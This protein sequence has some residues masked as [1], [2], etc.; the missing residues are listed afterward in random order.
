MVPQVMFLFKL[1][2]LYS[3]WLCFLNH[4]GNHSQLSET[5]GFSLRCSV[6][7]PFWFHLQKSSPI[8]T[9]CL[10]PVL[11]LPG[12]L[13]PQ[14]HFL[15]FVFWS[16]L[17][18]CKV[19]AGCLLGVCRESAGFRTPPSGFWGAWG[20][21]AGRFLQVGFCYFPRPPPGRQ[22]AAHRRHRP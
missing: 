17:G 15:P 5:Q 3:F 21:F 13:I 19:S 11:S 4:L 7:V 18:V 22:L 20:G 12:T 9:L 2:A 1:H 10:P 14:F 6:S 8:W 16:L